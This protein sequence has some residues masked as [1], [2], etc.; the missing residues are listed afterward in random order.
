MASSKTWKVKLRL[1]MDEYIDDMVDPT[2]LDAEI[3]LWC[4]LWLNSQAE[5]PQDVKKVLERKAKC[6]FAKY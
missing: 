5:L 2:S 6:R 1:F 4:N 3:N